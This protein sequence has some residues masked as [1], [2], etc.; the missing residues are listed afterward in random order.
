MNTIRTPYERY[1]NTTSSQARASLEAGEKREKAAAKQ[2][3]HIQELLRNAKEAANNDREAAADATKNLRAAEASLG[4][5][6]KNT[7]MS[8]ILV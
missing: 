2:M 5:H 6:D 4:E 7:M 8:I 1:L 3:D